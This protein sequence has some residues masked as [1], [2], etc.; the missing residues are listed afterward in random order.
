MSFL[1]PLLSYQQMDAK[2]LLRPAQRRSIRKGWAITGAPAA[3]PWQ[4]DRKLF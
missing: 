1:T 3:G 4:G 2:R